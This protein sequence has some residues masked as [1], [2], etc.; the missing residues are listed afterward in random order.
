MSSATG[1][2]ALLLA[3]AL[4]A[5]PVLG[6]TFSVKDFGAA[7][8]GVTDDTAAFQKALQRAA[9][10]NGSTVFAPAGRY[11]IAGSLQIPA[12][13]TL[14]G[15]YRGPGR[16]RGTVLLSTYG[17]G[18][19][20]GP[21][22][23]MATAGGSAVKGICIEY[24]DQ[25]ADAAEPVPFPYAIHAG[26]DGRVEDIFL[27]NAYQGINLDGAHASLVRNIWGEPLRVGIHADHIYDVCRIEN[28]HF[29]PYFTLDKPL[30]GWVLSHGVAFEFGRS[31]WQYCLNTFCYGYRVGYRFFTSQ[32]V[33]EKAYPGGVTNG[34]FVG[35][36]A[37]CVGVALDI[38]DSFNIGI[39]ITNGE[40]A[41]FGGTHCVGV[42]LHETNTGNVTLTNCNFWAVAEA[43]AI[44]NGGSLNLTGCNINDWNVAKKGDLPAFTVTKG[45]LNVTGCTFN[46]GGLAALLQGDQSRVS[47]TNNMG[48]EPLKVIN[49]IG[50]RALF[51]GNNPPIEVTEE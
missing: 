2:I 9:E 34:N 31:D 25:K 41:P 20:D 11:L 18:R 35:I 12:A 10:Q 13:T 23:I 27:Y 44:V 50:A 21:G 38:Q 17:K 16:Q 14:Q 28:V 22:C 7:A 45:R 33:K 36:G 46:S 47:F 4:I 51:S 32:E 37:D 19:T 8:D 15:E 1:I 49:R 24:P 6:G 39:S 42:L 26:P 5:A 43:L 29:W 3:W 30:R 48:S 40:F